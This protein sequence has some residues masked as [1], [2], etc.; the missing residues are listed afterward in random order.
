MLVEIVTAAEA[1]GLGDDLGFALVLLR[2]QHVMLDAFLLQHRRDALRL[3]DRDRTDQD[4]LPARVPLA[5][6]LDHRVELLALGLVDDVGEVVADHRLV[7][8]HDHHL[9]VVDL[10]ELDGL[11]IGGA[12]HA[13]ELLVHAEVVLERDGRERLVFALD[14]DVLL[15]L[16]RLVQPVAPAP[17][18]HEAAGE[19][20][21]DED[22]AVLHDV[23]DVA[24]VEG[25][26]A[27][28]LVHVVEGV[29]LARIVE[30]RDAQDLL[31]L[32]DAVL[33]QDRVAGLLVDGE[34][35]LLLQTRDHAIDD[36]VLLGRLLGR[37]GDDE[38]RTRLVDQDR[39]DLVD[40][41]VVEELVDLFAL[42][43]GHPI[44]VRA[45]H[46][47]LERELHVVAQ[48][49][50]AE[51]VVLPVG[52][53]GVVGVLALLVV[54]SV[55]DDARRKARGRCRSV[56]STRRRGAPGSR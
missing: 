35:G 23:L 12:G 44:G 15:G 13:R 11:G 24:L 49:V 26:R 7:R 32:G 54:E 47:L 52:D 31:D 36:V 42:G 5:D 14:L 48:I 16:D 30:V 19:L 25:V 2:V 56:P 6:V 50:E 39:V 53:V 9:E 51:L 10:V 38:R 28:R 3:L 18:G 46:V 17:A 22:L 8:R 27:Q 55:Q 33:G 34:V 43:V 21:D 4:G 41:R 37:A 20:V 45:V 40:D 1:T 29:D